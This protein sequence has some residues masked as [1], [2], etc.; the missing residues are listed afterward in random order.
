MTVHTLPPV[1]I[2]RRPAPQPP[3]A[4][5]AAP[6]TAA[7]VTIVVKSFLRFDCLRRCL[8]SARFFYPGVPI[9][10][11][12]DSLRAGESYEQHADA[13]Y[14]RNRPGV[15]WLQLPFDSGVSAGRNAGVAAVRT[16]LIWLIDDDHVIT[17]ETKLEALLDVLN[18][19]RSVDLVCGVIREVSRG[20]DG[21]TA[22]NWAADLELNDGVLHARPPARPWQ[23]TPAGTWYRR[24]D[25]FINVFLTRRGFLQ[26]CPWSAE[27]KIA[28]EHLDH[29]LRVWQSG[30]GVAYTPNCIA[31]EINA[32]TPTYAAF[33]RR[34]S[35]RQAEEAWDVREKSGLWRT[36]AETAIARRPTRMPA[37]AVPNIL[38]LT[39]GHTGSSL[40][41]GLFA[42]LGWQLPDNDPDYNEP[43][44]IR[45]ANDCLRRGRSLDLQPLIEP[46][47]RPWLLKDPRFTETLEAWL[48]A[49]APSQPLLLWLQR[50]AAAV[51]AS[52]ERRGESVALL[53]R[54][55]RLAEKQFEY[56][57]WAKQRVQFE[58]LLAWSGTVER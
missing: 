2:N 57:P 3:A 5:A 53:D 17:A 58:D 30:A 43:R 41:A 9:V 23:Q 36:F 54:R 46:L 25:R 24:S 28:G 31:G 11:V 32:N 39:V 10:V 49:F 47:P 42:R 45:R 22:S 29:V 34:S 48:P 21:A 13:V 18:A 1:Y 33:R 4:A 50:D 37:A 8:D 16:P 52:W 51:R 15:T 14:C 56:W 55:S 44:R 19:D 6:F 27:H 26:K 35:E 38:L 12:D 20:H 40:A 7:D